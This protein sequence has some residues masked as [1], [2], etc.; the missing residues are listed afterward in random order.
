LFA[1]VP[2]NTCSSKNVLATMFYNFKFLKF[3]IV[4]RNLN[5]F[6]VAIEILPTK[7]YIMDVGKIG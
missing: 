1:K 3:F 4:E 5:V 6:C 7:A 2:C